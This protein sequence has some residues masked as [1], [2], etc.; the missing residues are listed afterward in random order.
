MRDWRAT[1]LATLADLTPRNFT[2]GLP[3]IRTAKNLATAA[4]EQARLDGEEP[5][6]LLAE[7]VA[8]LAL[9]LREIKRTVEQIKSAQ[10]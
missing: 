5:L 7:A 9:E 8:K 1:H 10:R 6:A 3:M 4:A 2:K